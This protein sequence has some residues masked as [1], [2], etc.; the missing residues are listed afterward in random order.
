MNFFNQIS[1]EAEE[2][3]MEIKDLM[4]KETDT[5]EYWN[6]R[7]DELEDVEVFL[8][9]FKE[10]KENELVKIMWA[11]GIPY[12][13]TLT[14]RGKNYERYKVKSQKE[15]KEGKDFMRFEYLDKD[16]EQELEKLL[17][18]KKFPKSDD[19]DIIQNLIEKGY[20]IG[21]KTDP[22]GQEGN[23]ICIIEGIT[24]KGKT[25]FEMKECYEMQREKSVITTN[26]ISI[27]TN[28]DNSPVNV[29]QGNAT[30]NQIIDYANND[31]LQA[32]AKFSEMIIAEKE[33]SERERKEIL[34]LINGAESATHDKNSVVLKALFS[35][36]R[37]SLAKAPSLI[38]DKW[39]EIE[40]LFGL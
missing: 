24:Y 36:I 15:K 35:V 2:L 11:S 5:E 19:R 7:F 22:F 21:S 18:E 25:Y 17:I 23:I 1:I 10:L 3:L 4:I 26:H 38:L 39:Q 28:G 29:A 37:K 14:N 32:L 9:L 34:E 13:L 12:F 20:L 27:N 30:A 31:Q 16:S 8:S 33:I 40:S 6:T